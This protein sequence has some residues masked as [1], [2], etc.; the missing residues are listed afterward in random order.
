MWASRIV[1]PV[2]FSLALV[3][4][5]VSLGTGHS[6]PKT[7]DLHS[8]CLSP[9]QCSATQILAVL[10]FLTSAAFL[11]STAGLLA[12]VPVPH[13][14]TV[15]WRLPIGTK[16]EQSQG[17]V[18]L[19]PFCQGSQ[20]CTACSVW[21]WLFY[22]FYCFSSYTRW[23]SKSSPWYSIMKGSWGLWFVYKI[24]FHSRDL[25]NNFKSVP[26]MNSIILK[27]LWTKNQ[28]QGPNP[29]LVI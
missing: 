8:L 5:F 26:Y 13:S 17:S 25:L 6:Q 14:C 7:P 3:S 18:H 24:F 23:E 21:K 4:S 9:L 16:L 12:S 10:T 1:C 11:L 28:N 27:A 19:F 22:L 15:A 2:V 20:C 29:C